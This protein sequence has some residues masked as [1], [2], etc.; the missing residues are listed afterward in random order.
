[1]K[2]G[3]RSELHLSIFILE[4]YCKYIGNSNTNTID[5]KRAG[6]CSI[7]VAP[8]SQAAYMAEARFMELDEMLVHCRV[9]Q[10]YIRAK[11][12]FIHLCAENKLQ[13]FFAYENLRIYVSLLKPDNET[14]FIFSVY[15]LL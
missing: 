8:E 1:M 5:A 14:R 3:A 4:W 9:S 11:L 6:V 15:F 13:Y 2:H 12:A 10:H 7:R